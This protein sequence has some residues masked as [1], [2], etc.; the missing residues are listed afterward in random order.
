MLS[1]VDL[2][3]SV[4]VRMNKL[5]VSIIEEDP[6]LEFIGEGRSA[7]V[8]RIKSTNKALK[9]FFPEYEHIALEEAEIYEVLQGNP[10]YPKLHESGK[11][12]ILIDYIEG[13]T[14]FDCLAYGIKLTESNIKDTDHALSLARQQGLTPRDIH[15]RNIILTTEGDIKLIDVARFKQTQPCQQW[16]DLKKA[17]YM[18]YNKTYFPRKIPAFVLNSIAYLYKK[19]HVEVQSDK[20]N[21]KWTG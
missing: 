14:L 8:F 2:A 20:I 1:I 15:L 7:V 18:F 21:K 11:N 3:D 10:Y 5:G 19:K 6:V 13:Y 12:F 17:F 9:V 4:K 16:D